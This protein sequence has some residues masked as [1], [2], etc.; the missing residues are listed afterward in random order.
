[1][2]A[3]T[4]LKQTASVVTYKTQFELISNRIKGLSEKRKLSCFLN[5]LRDDIRLLVR[6]LNSTT[7]NAA[8]GLA[9]MQ[10]DHVNTKRRNLRQMGIIQGNFQRSVTKGI[11]KLS[12]LI[13]RISRA[14]IAPGS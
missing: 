9:K 6:M 1:M 8:F 13:Q 12:I 5:G 7:L 3:L 11:Q 2:E 10:G 4:R 14:Q